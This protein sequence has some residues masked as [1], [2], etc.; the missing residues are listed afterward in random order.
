MPLIQRENKKLGYDFFF[1]LKNKH[2]IIPVIKIEVG[3]NFICS[4]I[5]SLTG[6]KIDVKVEGLQSYKK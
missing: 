2:S 1:H 3:I 4:K 6:K 5:L